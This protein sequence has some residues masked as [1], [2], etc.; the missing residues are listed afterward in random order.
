MW[1]GKQ[2]QSAGNDSTQIQTQTLVVVQGVTE[3]RAA[4]IAEITARKVASEFT[5][6]ARSAAQARI[7]SFDQQL[8]A[9]FA[10]KGLLE[11]FRDPGFQILLN[12]AQMQAAATENEADHEL[13]TKLLAERASDQRKPIHLAVTRAAEVIDSIDE[14]TLAGMTLLWYSLDTFSASTDPL[15]SLIGRE[16]NYHDLL[17]AGPLPKGTAWLDDLD[18]LDL[19]SVD[20]SQARTMKP[21]EDLTIDRRPGLFSRGLN[22]DEANEMRRRLDALSEGLASLVMPHSLAPGYFRI[23]AASLGDH[24]EIAERKGLS[25]G[26]TKLLEK[27]FEDCSCGTVDPDVK[28]KAIDFIEGLPNY[29]KI[30]TWFNGFN[31][32]VAIRITAPGIAIAYSNARRFNSL[33]GL[34]KLSNL[35]TRRP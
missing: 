22:E 17:N 1:K 19:I 21:L 11:T 27:I 26:Q 12:K 28:K 14:T 30:R 31:S 3:E 16:G 6:D 34:D 5:A 7:G 35:L 13:L 25:S 23:N 32:Q 20:H 18:L 2:R 9:E 15:Q 24:R 8:V 4:E 29:S 10:T 33:A